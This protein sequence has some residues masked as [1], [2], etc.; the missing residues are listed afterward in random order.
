VKGLREEPHPEFWDQAPDAIIHLLKYAGLAEV[1]A[2]A[3]A[4][5]KANESF[6]DEVDI[7]DIV[8]FIRSFY[9]ET[10]QLGLELVNKFWDVK[11][12]NYA[13]LEVL[14]SNDLEEVRQIG[15]GY[16][17]EVVDD[18]LSQPSFLAKVLLSSRAEVHERL[19]GLYIDKVLPVIYTEIARLLPAKN[20]EEYSA[21][22][23]METLEL[24]KV[25]DRDAVVAQEELERLSDSEDEQAMW[26]ALYCY[27]TYSR[28]GR[29]IP[30]EVIV[31]AVESEYGIL[32]S[33]GV[34][35]LESISDEKL[36]EQSTLIASCCTSASV[37]L[38]KGI[39][40]VLDRL[41]KITPEFGAEMVESL[42]PI[43]L[44]KE[45]SDGVHDDVLAILLGPLVCCGTWPRI[46]LIREGS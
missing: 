31:S 5:W 14:I 17:G 1:Q 24:L 3:H 2:F 6:V 7:E 33:M 22:L 38:R 29:L 25:K 42:Y 40:P 16:L 4:V 44:R 39:L 10:K 34:S 46:F 35:L 26:Y 37:E 18:S 23:A 32:R 36:I 45:Q 8:A 21:Q 15:Y 28:L 19:R 41:V 11:N 13:L 9:T 12:P 20:P 43:V 30:E 27:Q